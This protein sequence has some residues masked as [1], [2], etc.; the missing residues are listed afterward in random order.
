MRVHVER[1]S[2]FERYLRAESSN[3]KIVG[4]HHYH[5]TIAQRHARGAHSGMLPDMCCCYMCIEMARDTPGSPMPRP[6]DL[7]TGG[8]AATATLTS[9]AYHAAATDAASLHDHALQQK[10]LE[11]TYDCTYT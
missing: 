11:V 10:I 3:A 2:A 7:G 5:R 9:G 4:G 8:G 1:T 6:R